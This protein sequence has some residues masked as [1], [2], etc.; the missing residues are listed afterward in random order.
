MIKYG[1]Y[2]DGK[3]EIINGEDLFLRLSGNVSTK[4]NGG[5]IQ[6]RSSRN[7]V[8]NFSGIKLK[9]RGTQVLIMFM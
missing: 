5:F 2:S 7:L 8:N 6:V 4:N 3:A 1:W 9:V